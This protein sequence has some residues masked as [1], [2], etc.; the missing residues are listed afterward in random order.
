VLAQWTQV[1]LSSLSWSLRFARLETRKITRAQLR[2]MLLNEG[3][4]VSVQTISNWRNGRHAPKA[5]HQAVIA[6]V[7]MVPV[8]SIFPPDEAA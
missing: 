7:L 4:D 5:H 2:T 3:L 6:R 8:Q 1:R